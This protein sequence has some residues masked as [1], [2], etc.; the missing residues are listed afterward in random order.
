MKFVFLLF[1][2]CSS[3]WVWGNSQ[4]LQATLSE[5]KARDQKILEDYKKKNP[6]WQKAPNDAYEKF[7]TEW[8]RKALGEELKIRENFCKIDKGLCP[9]E[10]EKKASV[11]QT[12]VA[13]G[14][15]SMQNQ[16]AKN[17]QIDPATRRKVI[18]EAERAA[19]ITLCSRH[20]KKCDDL[21]DVDQKAAQ[22]EIRRDKEIATLEIEFT[23]KNPA[24]KKGD[25]PLRD[26]K[27]D[28]EKQ[29][30][31]KTL[32]LLKELCELNPNDAVFCLSNK[33][34]DEMKLDSEGDK[35]RVERVHQLY[36]ILKSGAEK[37]EESLINKHDDEW[38]DSLDCKKL[39]AQDKKEFTPTPLPVEEK[40]VVV[41]KKPEIIV[42]P[43]PPVITT[44]PPVEE[45][46]EIA[47]SEV[48][49]SIEESDDEKSPRN[50]NAESCDWVNDLPRRIVHGPSCGRYSNSICT[51][52]VVCDQK[53]G[54]GK[55]VRM[56]TCGPEFC[57][58][59]K[60]DAVNCTK[61]G[62]YFSRKP[63][64]ETRELVT[65]KLKKMLTGGAIQE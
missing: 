42:T 2:L 43:P 21:D 1:I 51:G 63:A 56:S 45:K 46:R 3:S 39:L 64:D 58:G 65:P 34:K 27:V 14:L 36:T 30:L 54:G 59:S 10:K 55:F 33:Q 62:S 8:A 25:E 41:E 60:R 16:L 29:R 40:I 13:I 49:L 22:L 32:G 19:N 50:Y 52:Y 18:S 31:E 44:P 12:N 7:Y 15:I 37:K 57:G 38:Y 24:A 6:D 9:T 35:C 47:S 17:P 61:Q 4:K 48:A 5:Q 26:F 23:Q 11:A 53:V 28:L 20:N